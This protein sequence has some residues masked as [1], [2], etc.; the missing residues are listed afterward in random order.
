MTYLPLNDTL[1]HNISRK[2][3][4][5]KTTSANAASNMKNILHKLSSIHIKYRLAS[6]L[7]FLE[8]VEEILDG[9]QLSYLKDTVWKK[10]Y[11]DT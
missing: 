6:E 9:N 4:N 11:K 2:F 1:V 8:V 3:L 7:G 10:G 5:Y